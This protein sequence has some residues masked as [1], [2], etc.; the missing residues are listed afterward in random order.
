MAEYVVVL[1]PFE[2]ENEDL[3][4]YATPIAALAAIRQALVRV[5]PGGSEVDVG[6]IFGPDDAAVSVAFDPELQRL[7]AERGVSLCVSIYPVG[8][9]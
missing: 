6:V 8:E 4:E 5:A 7:A 3:G 9:F 1:R 2:G